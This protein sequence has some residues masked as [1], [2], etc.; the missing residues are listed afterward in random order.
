MN[1]DEQALT[2]EVEQTTQTESPTV[3][4]TTDTEAVSTQDSGAPKKSAQNRIREVISENHSLK[5]KIAQLTQQAPQPSY[6]YQPQQPKPLVGSDEVIDG[7]ELE[8]RM[9]EREQ[10]IIQHA[11]QATSFQIQQARVIDNINRESAEVVAQ[12]KELDPESE[13]FDKELSDT[14][15]EAVEAKVKA[16][17]TASV[18]AFVKKQ[19]ALYKREQAREE[20]QTN[21]EISKQ[22]AQGA[23]RPTA[24]KT[25][26]TKNF[27]ELSINEMRARLGYAD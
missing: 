27:E 7:A 25:T 4:K 14:I 3:E 13:H 24:V 10:F 18:K 17:P 12:Y 16:D 5:E 1:E 15:Y 20:A 23:I 22:A 21:A 9:Q 6:N 8:R 11:N 2:P 19:M 26:D